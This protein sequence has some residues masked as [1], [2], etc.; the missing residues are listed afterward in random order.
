MRGSSLAPGPILLE[1]GDVEFDFDTAAPLPAAFEQV[2]Q[3]LGRFCRGLRIARQFGKPVCDFVASLRLAGCQRLP[4]QHQR[5]DVLAVVADRT[6]AF[7]VHLDAVALAFDFDVL[8]IR[9][10]FRTPT[11]AVQQH[12]AVGQAFDLVKTRATVAKI[13]AAALPRTGIG[14]ARQPR[15]RKRLGVNH[16][17]KRRQTENSSLGV[18]RTGS[19][20][21]FSSCI[22]WIKDAGVSR[23]PRPAL[24]G[25]VA[26]LDFAAEE[27][28]TAGSSSCRGEPAAGRLVD[29][30]SISE[31]KSGLTTRLRTPCAPVS[32][33][34][35]S[36][37]QMPTV[38]MLTL[39]T[40]GR[41]LQLT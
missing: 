6:G 36:S 10:D 37:H 22:D 24:R 28:K 13:S 3:G 19:L 34:M 39:A 17:N 30:E 40:S 4:G 32:S 35:L 21:K 12:A 27:G 26:G 23:R 7:T 15:G 41:T 31:S 9:L 20:V 14:R 8:P 38:S 11:G 2:Q 1:P 33:K 29:Q 5:D 25:S 16:W 18:Y